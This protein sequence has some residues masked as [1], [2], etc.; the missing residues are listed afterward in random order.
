[1]ILHNYRLIGPAY[2]FTHISIH[3]FA[4]FITGA[5]RNLPAG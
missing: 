2:M 3:R 4:L 5:R 1:M